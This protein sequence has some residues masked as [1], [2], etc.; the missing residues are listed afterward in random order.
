[1]WLRPDGIPA[2]D[3]Q[4]LSVNVAWAPGSLPLGEA[5]WL[6]AASVASYAVFR[7]T[8]GR[9]Q[10]QVIVGDVREFL[11]ASVV[12]AYDLSLDDATPVEA[13]GSGAEL[14]AVALEMERE[15]R[16]RALESEQSLIS[17]HPL[18]APE[19]AQLAQRCRNEQ[20]VTHVMLARAHGRT[21][22]VFAVH[23]IDCGLP[24]YE[25]RAGFYSYWSSAG[26]ALATTRERARVEGERDALRARLL[27]DPLTGLP[28]G[29]ALDQRLRE[30]IH[31]TPLSVVALDFDGMRDA[32]NVFKSYELGG[33]VLIRAVGAALPAITSGQEFAARLHRGGDE[34]GV[35][36]P[37]AD[38]T[39]A[40]RRAREIEAALD[41]L[42][43][44]ASHRSVY[45][46]ASVGAATRSGEETPGQVL[47][48]AIAA[49]HRRKAQR[50]TAR[51]PG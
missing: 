22:G 20:I 31:T 14:P 48:R 29:T 10:R 18:L 35:V 49:M 11:D 7:E 51:R 38:E 15:L 42:D 45:R 25:R 30:H 34:F 8:D 32:N 2:D 33:D 41:A 16:R 17:N 23:W 9:R 27:I 24:P 21:H 26:V 46:G 50:R 19:L 6:R 40:T 12:R 39:I 3:L 1:M 28:N 5:E 44:P 13:G 43:V 37:Y 47:G 4:V 36:L